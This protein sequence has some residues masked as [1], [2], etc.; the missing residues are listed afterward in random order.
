MNLNSSRLRR[1]SHCFRP[2]LIG[3]NP[4]APR[5]SK[6]CLSKLFHSKWSDLSF[7]AYCELLSP[8][9]AATRQ[10]AAP[11]LGGHALAEAMC[12][13]TLSRVRLK[14]SFH[15]YSQ[16]LLLQ[17]YNRSLRC[18]S[19]RGKRGCPQATILTISQFS[20]YKSNQPPVDLQSFSLRKTFFNLPSLGLHSI[21]L[22]SPSSASLLITR[23]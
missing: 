5:L 19:A 4:F 11:V 7:V 16:K 21:I 12:V 23:E 18:S 15:V 13:F 6:P 3:P 14:R 17:T 22:N 20:E 10:H 2:R 1:I 9:C 8:F